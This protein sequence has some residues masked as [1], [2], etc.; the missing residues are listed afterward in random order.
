VHGEVNRQSA[1]LPL[2]GELDTV[3]AG[4]TAVAAFAACMGAHIPV[5]ESLAL[6][7]LASA[8]SVQKLNQTGSATLEEIVE[9]VREQQAVAFQSPGDTLL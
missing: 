5:V 3:G 6:A 7:N 4:D 8:V 1:A 9:I 2:K